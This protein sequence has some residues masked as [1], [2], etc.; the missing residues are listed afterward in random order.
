[1]EKRTSDCGNELHEIRDFDDGLNASKNLASE[2]WNHIS[3]K[4][5]LDK[6]ASIF[7][8]III[9]THSNAVYFDG[10]TNMHTYLIP[11]PFWPLKSEGS[12][13]LE[14]RTCKINNEKL[15]CFYYYR[16]SIILTQKKEFI[17]G[18]MVSHSSG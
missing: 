11:A 17:A 4:E 9:D 13:S 5:S 18:R 2:L 1:M 8:G 7:V 12:I 14:A 16:D 6:H 3:N 10:E 15:K